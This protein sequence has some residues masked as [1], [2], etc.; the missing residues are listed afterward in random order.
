MGQ[1]LAAVPVRAG[2]RVAVFERFSEA[3]RLP[4][5][6]HVDHEIMRLLQFLGLSEV[7]ADEMVPVDEYRWLGADGEPL[8]RFEPRSPAPSGWD[9]DYMFFQPELERAID[10]HA[11]APGG[12]TV[13]RGWAAEGLVRHADIGASV[14]GIASAPPCGGSSHSANEGGISTGW[15]ARWDGPAHGS[16]PLL[17]VRECLLR[18]ERNGEIT[19]SALIRSK[20][21]SPHLSYTSVVGG[22]TALAQLPH[23]FG[24]CSASRLSSVHARP[25]SYV[26]RRSRRPGSASAV[27]SK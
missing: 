15:H 24:V 13:T 26:W 11:C 16:A 6:V 1:T 22:R 14:R 20:G 19:P 12:V 3:Y 7:L 9:A 18:Q 17:C 4:R 23:R 21:W 25:G 27:F 2:P 10:S 5:A 8:L